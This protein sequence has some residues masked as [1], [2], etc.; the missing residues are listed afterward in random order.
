M[1]IY[2]TVYQTTN[3][4]N[5]RTYVG[6]HRTH[7]PND[8]YLGSGKAL[9]TAVK[10]Y[11]KENFRKE[12]LAICE[13]EQEMFEL[14]RELV[15]EDV[16]QDRSNYNL[17]PGGRE[18]KVISYEQR[19][20]ISKTL[21]EYFKDNRNHPFTNKRH[22]EETRK[23]L[24]DIHTGK[25]IS[26]ETNQKRSK[27]LMGRNCLDRRKPVS[28]NGVIYESV[29]DAAKKLDVNYI[30]AKWRTRNESK[31]WRYLTEDE[32]PDHL[33]S[34]HSC[35][36]DGVTFKTMK[37]A[38]LAHGIEP[39]TAIGRFKSPNFPNWVKVN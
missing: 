14:E 18:G 32:T 26:K 34:A 22:T 38:A 13:T 31:G 3:L 15:S 17:A 10:K 24:S 6:V 8:D 25:K 11:G 33:K 21:K 2:Y 27:S 35:S 9:L 19:A 20:D 29:A 36:V 1:S 23:H 39:A 37:D 5:G 16:T 30:T 7:D 4:I 12:V 28:V